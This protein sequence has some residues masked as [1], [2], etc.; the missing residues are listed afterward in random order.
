VESASEREI[1]AVVESTEGL[2]A[3]MKNSEEYFPVSYIPVVLRRSQ[4]YV[5]KMGDSVKLSL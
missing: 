2:I 1:V 5:A 3:M 4:T